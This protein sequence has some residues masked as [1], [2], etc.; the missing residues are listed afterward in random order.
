[1]TPPFAYAGL[2]LA[3]VAMFLLARRCFP[4]SGNG[5]AALPRHERLT[6]NLAAFIGGVLGAKLPFVFVRGADWFGTAWLADGKTVSTGLIGAYTAVELV[7]WFCGIKVK[8]GDS[9][10]LPLALALAVGRWGCFFHGC[11][12]GVPTQLPWGV[13]FGDGVPRHPT[14]VYESLFHFTMAF[15]LIQVI[16]RGWF[17]NQRL[18]LYLISYGIYRFLTEFIR[19]EPEY[20]LGLTYFQWVAVVLVIGLSMQWCYEAQSPPATTALEPSVGAASQAA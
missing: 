17:R 7:K 10:A 8:T 12:Y 13:D 5:L 14:Q 6:I 15:V 4:E 2:M 1:M 3:A 16:R 18:K 9:F 19:P 20:S 11:C